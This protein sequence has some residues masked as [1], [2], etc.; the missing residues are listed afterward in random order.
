MDGDPHRGVGGQ[1]RGGDGRAE[2]LGLVRRCDII[3]AHN[4]GTPPVNHLS[5]MKQVTTIGV[6][7]TVR[8]RS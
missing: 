5:V 7:D 8:K 3:H 4:R 1:L 6:T 2:N